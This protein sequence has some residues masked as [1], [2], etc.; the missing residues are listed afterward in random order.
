MKPFLLALALAVAPA[1]AYSQKPPKP[2]VAS[3]PKDNAYLG[4]NPA[5]VTDAPTYHR[6]KRFRRG[7]ASAASAVA[8]KN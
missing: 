1:L 4:D 3:T 2:V 6:K 7:A 5:T 8:P